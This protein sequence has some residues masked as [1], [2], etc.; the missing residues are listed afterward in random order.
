M[1]AEPSAAVQSTIDSIIIGYGL[2]N[3]TQRDII[4]AIIIDLLNNNGLLKSEI[5][6]LNQTIE[7]KWKHIGYLQDELKK[8]EEKFKTT[9]ITNDSLIAENTAISAKNKEL[10][11][12]NNTFNAR[13]SALRG[14]IKFLEK[15]ILEERQK[16]TPVFEHSNV[17][18]M[19]T[20][21][22]VNFAEFD[23][24]S[25]IETSERIL[26]TNGI[27]TK[28]TSNSCDTTLRCDANELLLI[29]Y[30]Y[31]EFDHWI[32]DVETNKIIHRADLHQYFHNNTILGCNW[33]Y[34]EPSSTDVAKVIADVNPLSNNRHNDLV[35]KLCKITP[36]K[37]RK[38][39]GI[40]EKIIKIVS[41]DMRNA[42]NKIKTF[43]IAITVEDVLRNGNIECDCS[44]C[45][46]T[47]DGWARSSIASSDVTR[48][49]TTSYFCIIVLGR[50]LR[51]ELN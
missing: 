51:V 36:E 5:V 32:V 25:T 50:Q 30:A 35:T 2:Q 8:I 34:I 17:E 10:L 37:E 20:L 18:N 3:N 43:L 13:L 33:D 42:K 47:D 26:A 21:T 4:C 9:K 44:C 31:G 29:V 14:D 22:S 7:S 19:A 16:N 11:A 15:T 39:K 6:K 24:T 38:I 23:R 46:A 48:C 12:E 41:V 49:D 1:S 28:V 27:A 45:T 40:N